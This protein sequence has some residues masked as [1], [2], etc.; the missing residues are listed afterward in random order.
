[1]LIVTRIVSLFVTAS[2]VCAVAVTFLR[3]QGVSA[4]P[5]LMLAVLGAFLAGATWQRNLNGVMTGVVYIAGGTVGAIVA[6]NLLQLNIRM[7]PLAVF[8]GAVCGAAAWTISDIVSV[9]DRLRGVGR[10]GA[11]RLENREAKCKDTRAYL[12]VSLASLI[13][14]PVLGGLFYVLYCAVFDVDPMDRFQ[15]LSYHAAVGTVG[16]LLVGLPYLLMWLTRI[17]DANRERQ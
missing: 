14:G 7:S 12:F 5:L 3:L 1:M 10:R 15:Y 9:W 16:G 2:A 8:S 4:L 13:G 17:G 6:A 11:I